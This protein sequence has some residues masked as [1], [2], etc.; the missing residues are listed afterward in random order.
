[1]QKNEKAREQIIQAAL[2]LFNTCGYAATSIQDIIRVTGLTKGSIYRRFAGKEEI[3]IAAFEYGGMVIWKKLQEEISRQKGIVNK[4]TAFYKIYKEPVNAPI[5]N[6]GCP[7]LNAATQ[8]QIKLPRLHEIAAKNYQQMIDYFKN[9]I[10]QG[11][12][13]GELRQDTDADKLA[14]ILMSAGEGAI[15]ASRLLKD[16]KHMQFS[17]E[18]IRAL[19]EHYK[20]PDL[21][22]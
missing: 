21:D 1:M 3:A 15:M 4:L 16:N 10:Q 11:I 5:I 12:K 22:N 6:G 20:T 17:E 14:S 9:L 13:R 18:W 8:T 7:M 19:L 2:E